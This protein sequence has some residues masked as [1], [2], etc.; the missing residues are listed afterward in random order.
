MALYSR[1]NYNRKKNTGWIYLIIVLLITGLVTYFYNPFSKTVQQENIAAVESK[2]KSAAQIE[3]K[4]V[5]IESQKEPQPQLASPSIPEIAGESNARA[6]ELINKA[7]G[8]LGETPA[9][10]IEA[11]DILNEV[12]PMSLSTRQRQFVKEQMSILADKWLF[13]R[14]VLPQDTLCSSYVVKTGDLLKDI[15][16]RHKVPYEIILQIN[17]IDNPLNLRAGETIKVI[18]GPFHVRIYRSTFTLDL[19]LQ[20]TFVKSFKVGLGGPGKETPTGLWLVKSDGKLISPTWTDPDTGKTYEAESPDYPLGSRWIGL[21][22]VSGNAKGRTGFA[23]HGTKDMESI[24]MA[25]SRGCI[26]LYNGEAI[27]LYNILMQGFSQVEV[28]E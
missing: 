11:R 19:F 5:V 13:S 18:N 4:A 23:I 28:V 8:L 15:G 1:K 17:N 24:G 16:D 10:I 25:S 27:L 9:K 7:A 3:T 6:S 20:N 14:T 22:G 2:P 21:E 26:R 12:L